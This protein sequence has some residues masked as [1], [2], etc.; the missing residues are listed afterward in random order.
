ME[1]GC[2]V[3]LCLLLFA[4]FITAQPL[5]SLNISADSITVSGIS[6]GAAFAVQVH[7]VHSQI[8]KGAGLFAA[9]PYFCAKDSHHTA[10]TSCTK[11][12]DQISVPLLLSTTY[13]ASSSNLIDNPSHLSSSKIYLWSGTRDTIV[14]Q[15]VVNKLYEYYSHF[16]SS[17][18]RNIIYWNNVSSEHAWINNKYGNPCA[19]LGSPFV[20]NCHIDAPGQILGHFYGS[21]NLK[22]GQKYERHFSPFSQKLYL[23]KNVQT[24]GSI[25]M[26]ETGFIYV[27]KACQEGQQC[28]LHFCFHGCDQ[29]YESLKMEFVESTFLNEW[30]EGSKVVVVYPQTV[31]SETNPE[32][33]KGCWDWWGYTGSNYYTKSAPQIQTVYR[34]IEALKSGK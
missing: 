11:D 29:N 3:V 24:P 19:H 27:P 26:A 17:P 13:S 16:S 33:K 30:A 34:I 2:L 14:H 7:V 20:D 5:P 12:P 28:K 15:G 6:A 18:S 8:I 9:A 25:S 1:K 32:N 4:S 10:I 23:P 22:L 21:A 31:N